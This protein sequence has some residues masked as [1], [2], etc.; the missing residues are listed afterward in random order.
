VAYFLRENL[1]Y[2]FTKSLVSSANHETR[3]LDLFSPPASGVR[4]VNGQP[5]FD[6]PSSSRRKKTRKNRK[7]KW[8]ED[9]DLEFNILLNNHYYFYI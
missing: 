9:L 7:I 8:L 5:V 3:T 4:K 6:R 1:C 2:S